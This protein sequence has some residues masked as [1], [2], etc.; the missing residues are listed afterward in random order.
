MLLAGDIGG[1]KTNLAV[2]SRE[3]GV[4]APLR[5]ATFPSGEFSSLGALIQEFLADGDHPVEKASLGV[6]GPVIEGRVEVTNLPWNLEESRL[7]R[8]L[9]LSSVRLLNDLL[10]VAH[11][12]P[13]LEEEDLHTLREGQPGDG[14]RAVIAPGTGLGK[15]FLTWDGTRY[16][17]FP[18]EGGHADF[19]PRGE[20]QI[21]LLRHLQTRFDHVSCERVCSGSGIPNLY[22]FLVDS[23]AAPEPAWLKQKI[24]ESPDPTPVIINSALDPGVDCRVCQLTLEL[25]VSIL[26]AEAGNLALEVLATRGV[27]LGGGIPPRILDVLQGPMFLEAFTAKG[28]LSDLMAAVPVYVITNPKAA[29]LGAACHGLE[30][31]HGLD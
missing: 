26:G 25:F 4:R 17:P 27:Y 1:T 29:L 18:S 23:G 12:V 5:E 9:G 14:N 13:L 2:Y 24:R 19:A 8:E 30:L 10:A 6:A 21:D 16:Q 28:R 15:A 31:L 22:R 20:V 7:E 11:A 3:S